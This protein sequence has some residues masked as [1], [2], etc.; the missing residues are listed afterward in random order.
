MV[1]FV[2]VD[3]GELGVGGGGVVKDVW[4]Q[5]HGRGRATWVF[6]FEEGSARA[7]EECS[8]ILHDVFAGVYFGGAIVAGGLVIGL[9]WEFAEVADDVASAEIDAGV[10]D[11]AVFGFFKIKSVEGDDRVF[12][13]VEGA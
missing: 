11:G 2:V 13:D 3:A 6:G 1:V 10:G 12:V 4:F 9:G 5:L 8:V 7:G